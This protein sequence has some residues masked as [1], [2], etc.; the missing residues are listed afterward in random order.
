MGRG[1]RQVAEPSA[2]VCRLLLWPWTLSGTV[3]YTHSPLSLLATKCS[4]KARCGGKAWGSSSFRSCSSWPTGKGCCTAREEAPD[5][6]FLGGK[7]HLD[8]VRKLALLGCGSRLE[9]R[10]SRPLTLGHSDQPAVVGGS[11]CQGAQDL[12]RLEEGERG[13]LTLVSV[14]CCFVDVLCCCWRQGFSV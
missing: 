9:G 4:W 12:C 14:L 7:G 5:L 3:P 1:R 11:Q 6:G 10:W 13:G 2:P 8:P